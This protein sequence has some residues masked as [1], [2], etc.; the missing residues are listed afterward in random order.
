VSQWIVCRDCE[1]FETSA[2]A[3]EATSSADNMMA[4]FIDIQVIQVPML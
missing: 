2:E 1:N 4:L 3:R